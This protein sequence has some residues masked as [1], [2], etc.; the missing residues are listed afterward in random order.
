MKTLSIFDRHQLNIA[1]KTVN[2]PQAMIDILGG[3]TLNEAKEI[4]KRLTGK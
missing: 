2:M 3:M 1:R 4:I